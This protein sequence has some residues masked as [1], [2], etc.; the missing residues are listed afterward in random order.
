VKRVVA[1]IFPLLLLVGCGPLATSTPDLVATEVAVQRAAAATLTAEA[2]VAVTLT[3]MPT[4]TA[5][6]I[7]SPSATATVTIE[8]TMAPSATSTA[9]PVPVLPSPTEPAPPVEPSLGR[10]AV[11]DVASDD[12]LNIRVRP[13]ANQAIVGTIPYYGQGVEVYAGGQEIGGSWW[14]PVQYG[15]VQG[16]VNSEYLARQVGSTSDAVAARA[17]RVILAL[18][19]RDWAEVASLVH[20]VK[21][22]TFS[23]YTYVRP[24][25]GAPGEAD[26]VFSAT[27]LQALWSD[28]AVYHWGTYDGSGEPID[29]T[30]R[31]YHDR[32]IYD[33]DFARPD[34]VGFDQTIGQGNTINNIAAVYPNAVTVEYHFEGFDPQYAGLD[35]RSL[36]LVLEPVDGTWYLVGIVH[37]GWTI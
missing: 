23:P 6:V 2:P 31:E 24:L 29:L 9:S 33:V 13:G 12:M 16:W 30:F 36:R 22:V 11:V 25:Q 15:E 21:G 10:F 14:V 26:L 20:P 27:Q 28:P 37:D 3:P 4:G 34:V 35:W 7:P 17:A 8:P 32:F 1:L 19:D 18:K 5:V